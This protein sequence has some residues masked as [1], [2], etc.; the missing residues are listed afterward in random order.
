MAP[1][2]TNKSEIIEQDGGRRMRLVTSLTGYTADDISVRPT[3]DKVL[4]LDGA[5][6]VL[7]AFDAPESVDP[8]TVEAELS[9]NGVLTI[10]APLR[11]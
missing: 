1:H 8:Y 11:S 9:E 5:G 6:A 2:V 7:C 4:V 3:D 10:E